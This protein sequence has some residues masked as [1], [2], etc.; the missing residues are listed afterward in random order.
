MTKPRSYPS[1]FPFSPALVRAAHQ[2]FSFRNSCQISSFHGV[3]SPSLS[4]VR[5]FLASISPP[6]S[7]VVYAAIPKPGSMPACFKAFAFLESTVFL[8]AF[9]CAASVLTCSTGANLTPRGVS[10]RSRSTV[11]Q[12]VTFSPL[13]VIRPG[14]LTSWIS[15][16]GSVGAVPKS[17][18]RAAIRSWHSVRTRLAVKC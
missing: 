7:L 13:M 16:A 1:S 18:L 8:S 2:C 3:L 4:F 9:C 10:S 6:V 5:I 17:G 15:H 14:S 11:A 12:I